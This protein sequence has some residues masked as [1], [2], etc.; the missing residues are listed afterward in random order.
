MKDHAPEQPR[1]HLREQ[2]CAETAEL[3]STAEGLA[4]AR[5]LQRGAFFGR[6]AGVARQAAGGK[7]P[8]V[9]AAT[10]GA[11]QPDLKAENGEPQPISI[12]QPENADGELIFVRPDPL[13]LGDHYSATTTLK[14]KK[15]S[16]TRRICFFGESV[17]AGYLYAPHLTPAQVLQ[18]QLQCLAGSDQYEVIDLARTNESIPELLRTVRSSMQLEPDALVIFTGN[19][20]T[21]LNTPFATPYSP[22]IDERQLLALALREGGNPRVF[23]LATAGLRRVVS[24]AFSRISRIAKTAGI[25]VVIV[26][27]EINLADWETRQPVMWLPGNQTARWHQLYEEARLHLENNQWQHAAETARQMIVLDK[28]LCPTSHRVLACAHLGA[29]HLDE[30][31]GASQAEV[32]SNQKATLCFLSAPQISSHSK[33]QQRDLAVR[34]GFASVDLPRIFAESGYPLYSSDESSYPWTRAVG[35]EDRVC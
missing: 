34:L 6:T 12:W 4:R 10:S 16:Q 25:P 8:A 9:S 23:E 33:Q 31:Q 20:W 32:D 19:N 1:S 27:P 29:G 13:P 15:N 7:K 3:L 21:L 35:G 2:S 11:S 28:G 26:I 5:H 18:D 17:A 24:T 30:A 14:A 22:S